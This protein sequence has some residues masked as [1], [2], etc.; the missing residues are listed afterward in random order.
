MSKDLWGKVSLDERE[1]NRA[2]DIL[3]EQASI[4]G[5]KTGDCVKGT[6]YKTGTKL[7]GASAGL[8]VFK[9][10]LKTSIGV[11]EYSNCEVNLGEKE[12]YNINYRKEL[13]SFEIYNDEYRFRI[14]NLSYSKEYP[15][16]IIP[17]EGVGK[18]I[19]RN[20]PIKINDN[21]AL[22]N[23]VQD[24]FGSKKVRLVISRM[25]NQT[26]E[27]TEKKI[28]EFASKHSE[29][30]KKELAEEMGWSISNT[31]KRLK[32]LTEKGILSV[33]TSKPEKKWEICKCELPG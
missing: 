32:V 1:E 29:F 16:E 21:D 8:E 3:K 30:T 20:E 28:I 2:I 31:T 5:K 4:I 9:D 17:D 19:F 18:D 7:S 22:E 11:T 25:V 24:I 6:F 13:Y 10:V 14:F 33:T 23:I 26:Q 12:D 15:I 27:R